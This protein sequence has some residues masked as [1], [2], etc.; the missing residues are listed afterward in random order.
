MFYLKKSQT[1]PEYMTAYATRSTM[2]APSSLLPD[3]LHLGSIKDAATH[4]PRRS[5][6]TLFCCITLR[7][8]CDATSTSPDATGSSTSVYLLSLDRFDCLINWA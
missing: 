8:G 3:Q 6:F 1:Q 5:S 4:A 7:L 2:R